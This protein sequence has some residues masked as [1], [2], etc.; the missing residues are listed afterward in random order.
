MC[1][2]FSLTATPEEVAELFELEDIE[3]FPPRYN[4]APTQPV[5]M[6]AN[7]PQDRRKA[8]LVRW[9]LVPS[10]VK[11][12]ADFTL[13]INARSETAAE[14]PSFR[15]A[16]R[17]RRTLIPASG[18]Y[19][20]HRPEDKSQAKQ[21]YWIRPKNGG[22]VCFG[23]LMETWSS[24]NGSEI[25]SGCILTTS[26]NSAIAKIHNRMPVVIRPADFE[27]WLDCRNCEPRDMADLMQPI[28]NE[29]FEA[30]AVSDRVNKVANSGP[31]VQLPVT[32]Q[33]PPA[34]SSGRNKPVDN[35]TGK[36]DP[37]QLKLL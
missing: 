22:L 1:G 30:I 23:G 19:E 12:P 2:R 5:L 29:Y 20:W 15:N 13:L 34:K 16:M 26:A 32:V 7:G 14:K 9:G 25:D 37:D 24:A 31:D 28:D 35:S 6:V 8:I 11:D 10:W 4:I 3:P 33:E 18:F 36:D 17:H 21:A 27:R